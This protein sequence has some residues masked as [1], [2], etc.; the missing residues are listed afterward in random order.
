MLAASS[1]TGYSIPMAPN[2]SHHSTSQVCGSREIDLTFYSPLLVTGMGDEG[3][4]LICEAFTYPEG[5]QHLKHLS[6]W[7]PS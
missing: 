6:L 1:A 2:L 4:R 5:P 7:G 3:A